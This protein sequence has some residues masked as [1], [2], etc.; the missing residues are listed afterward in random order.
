MSC[1]QSD[2]VSVRFLLTAEAEPGS[3]SRL[4]APFARRSVVPDSIKAERRG[5]QL[6]VEIGL[7]A[8]P[9]ALLHAIEGNLRQ[10]VGVARLDRKEQTP[11]RA[12]AQED[13]AFLAR[14]RRAEEH[15][16]GRAYEALK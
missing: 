2:S 15:A 13:R 1:P 11:L 10:T 14:M 12:P 4:L 7:A 5:D 9:A 3:L 8:A 6:V 16:A